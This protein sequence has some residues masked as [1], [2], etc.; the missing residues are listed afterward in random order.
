MSAGRTIGAVLCLAAA[1]LIIVAG[2]RVI[3]QCRAGVRR[4]AVPVRCIVDRWVSVG[5]TEKGG[6]L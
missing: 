2:V 5:S 1:G 3:D 6:V 4:G